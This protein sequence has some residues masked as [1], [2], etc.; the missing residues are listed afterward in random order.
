MTEIL[1]QSSKIEKRNTISPEELEAIK[2]INKL[3]SEEKGNDLAIKKSL[4]Q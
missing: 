2:A 4:E 3:F 1:A